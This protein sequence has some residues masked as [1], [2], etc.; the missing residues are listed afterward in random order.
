M[1]KI[2]VA[3]LTITGHYL[4]MQPIEDAVR[5]GDFAL[6]KNISAQRVSVN[7]APPFDLKGYLDID[8]FI[9]QFNPRYQNYFTENIEWTSKHIED[10]YAV[11]SLTL[12]L[13]HKR[14]QKEIYYKFIFFMKKNKEWKIYYLKG[15]RI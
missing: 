15:L 4:M 10:T 3:L 8:A 7:L 5:S 9:R 12:V 14:S 11:Q 2:L 6:F 13:K 1:I